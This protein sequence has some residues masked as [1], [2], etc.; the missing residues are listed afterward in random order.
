MRPWLPG[1]RL[2]FANRQKREFENQH[3][4]NKLHEMS[5]LEVMTSCSYGNNRGSVVIVDLHMVFIK[6]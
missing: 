5:S 2:T 4:I 1:Q 3:M 6:Q